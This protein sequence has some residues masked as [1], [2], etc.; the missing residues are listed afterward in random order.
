[1]HLPSTAERVRATPHGDAPPAEEERLAL[2]AAT[3]RR[4][5]RLGS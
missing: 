3:R 1:V 4:R 5:S 2:L